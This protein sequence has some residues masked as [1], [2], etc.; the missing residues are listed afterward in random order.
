MRI[1]ILTLGTRGDVQPYVALG[2]QLRDR[3]HDV[4]ISTGRGFGAMIEAQGLRAAPISTDVRAL[5]QSPEIQRALR[6]LRGKVAA[7][8]TS[9]AMVRQQLDDTWDVARAL[10]PET[11]VYHPKA[12]VAPYLARALGAQ[13]IPSFLQPGYVPTGAFI[14]ALLPGADLGPTVNKLINRGIVHLMQVAFS[15]ALRDWLARQPTF[16][17]ARPLDVLAGYHPAGAPVLRLHAFSRHLVPRPEDWSERE[18]VT[19]YWFMP[20]GRAWTA[21]AALEAFLAAGPPP[22][23]V[24]FGSMPSEDAGRTTGLVVDALEQAGC[25]GIISTG[26]GGLCGAAATDRL[27]VLDAVPHDWLFPRCSVVVHHG[28]AGTTHE[29]LRWGRAS[30]VC[31]VFG[32]QPFWARRVAALGAGPAP[33]SQKRLTAK[34]LA[35]A[36]SA[37]QGPAM[38]AQAAA[39]GT[40]IRTEAG[41]ETA[42]ALIDATATPT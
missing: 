12:F 2:S 4:T 21:P 3:G 29:A 19:G 38:T 24:G 34:R 35:E 33:L 23:Y 9:K 13:A 7:W 18:Q 37:A 40:K 22:V 1:L 27:Y 42:A 20:E 5:L 6:T 25:R 36:V 17:D 41:A 26:W 8:R 32:D 14:P 16:A 30:V 39:V 10:Q 31:P 15:A 28:G 11:I